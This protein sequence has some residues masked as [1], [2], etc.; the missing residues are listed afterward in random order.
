[1]NDEL[2]EI[3]ISNLEQRIDRLVQ[4][5][6]QG[7]QGDNVQNAQLQPFVPIPRIAGE[8][9]K[10]FDI[11]TDDDDAK[12]V[13]RCIFY[14][15]KQEVELADYSLDEIPA[16]GNATLYLTRSISEGE[17]VYALTTDE[18]VEGDEDTSYYKIYDFTDGEVS[19]DYRA[20]FLTLGISAAIDKVSIDKVT[21]KDS[22]D[23][24]AIQFKNFDNKESDGGQGLA[25]RLEIR[26]DGAGE[27]AS[28]RIVTKS[29]DS[30][31]HLVARVNGKLKY[32]P[33]SGREEKDPDEENPPP[34]PEDCS[35]PGDT[36]NSGGVSPDD[37]EQ[38][39]HHA[40]GSA[41]GGVPPGGGFLHPGDD[42]CNC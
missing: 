39:G 35:H 4:E 41:I 27:S 13:V 7:K 3:R 32:I 28:F 33:L 15:G 14:W 16:T 18:P 31:V 9:P 24:D 21:E 10:P 23:P 25:E 1:M 29:N 26:R 22:E 36:D 12:S 30:K 5:L 11:E 20:T 6:A 2:A 17:P 8:D 38:G 34:D 37:D 42:N 40:S 19:C